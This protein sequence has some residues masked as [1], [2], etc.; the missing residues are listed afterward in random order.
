MLFLGTQFCSAQEYLSVAAGGGTTVTGG[1]GG[2]FQAQPSFSPD[3]SSTN[4]STM[5]LRGFIGFLISKF[6]APAVGIIFALTFVYFLWNI[7]EVI[8]KGGSAEELAKFKGKVFWGIITLAVMVSLWG[9]VAILMRT[10]FPGLG[11]S[12]PQLNTNPSANGIFR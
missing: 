7:V 4:S 2:S 11:L 12:I 9:L 1:T 3:I 5:D 6:I 8:R 10:F